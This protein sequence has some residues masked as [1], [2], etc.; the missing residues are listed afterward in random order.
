MDDDRSDAPN[1][2]NAAV[3]GS[4]EEPAASG[5]RFAQA[6]IIHRARGSETFGCSR[7]GAGTRPSRGG[8]SSASYSLTSTPHAVADGVKNETDRRVGGV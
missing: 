3:G 6:E 8:D 7:L 5:Q 2:P 1:V 4:G